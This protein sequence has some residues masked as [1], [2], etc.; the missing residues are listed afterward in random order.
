[1]LHKVTWN[2]SSSLSQ[3]AVAAG[4]MAFSMAAAAAG[5][6]YSKAQVKES[7]TLYNSYCATCHRTDLSGAQGPALKGEAFLSRYKT[8]ADLYNYTNKTMP[9]TSPGS[10]PKEDLIK[11]M[12]FIFSENG[13]PSGAELTEGS[14]DRPLKP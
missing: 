11:I 10:V 12:A 9:P 14:L 8:G 5:G 7:E 4:I 1:M 3:L 13:L 2:K 6:W